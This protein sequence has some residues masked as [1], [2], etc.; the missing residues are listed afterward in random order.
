VGEAAATVLT[1]GQQALQQQQQGGEQGTVCFALV[2]LLLPAI[3]IA[4]HTV[5]RRA[6]LGTPPQPLPCEERGF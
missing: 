6:R 3:V 2:P 5:A 4:A 1:L